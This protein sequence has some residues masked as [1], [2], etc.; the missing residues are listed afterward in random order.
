MEEHNLLSLK[1]SP[2]TCWL[3]LEREVKGVC[4]NR[5]AVVLELEEEEAARDCLVA[6]YKLRVL[7]TTHSL[8]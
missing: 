2:A 7:E 8:P 6:K 5:V 4:A 3:S 1:Q